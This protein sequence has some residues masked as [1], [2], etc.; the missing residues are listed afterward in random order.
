[1]QPIGY[2]KTGTVTSIPNSLQLR[3]R[4]Q[5]ARPDAG[6]GRHGDMHDTVRGYCD[7][8]VHRLP[9]RPQRVRALVVTRRQVNIN[10][11]SGH[12][13]YCPR[14]RTMTHTHTHTHTTYIYLSLYL[15]LSHSVMTTDTTLLAS[16]PA[17]S[18]G[19]WP[20]THTVYSPP[21]IN[22]PPPRVVVSNAA[23]GRLNVN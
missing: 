18:S 5:P 15:S 3:H 9:Y 12:S 14:T 20:D 13:R 19:R 6:E 21:V 23:I 4:P 1:M 8:G 11:Y 16:A 10:T 17:P 7:L 2:R 22:F